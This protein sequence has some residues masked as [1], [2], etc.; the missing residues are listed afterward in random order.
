MSIYIFI[1]LLF[2]IVD[3]FLYGYGAALRFSSDAELEEYEQSKSAKARKIKAVMEHTSKFVNTVHLI[4][5][6]N[7]IIVGMLH[8]SLYINYLRPRTKDS[9]FILRGIRFDGEDIAT[10]LFVLSAFLVLYL[11]L[12]FG[13]LLPKKLAAKAAEKWVYTFITPIWLLM[14]V[15]KPVTGLVAGTVKLV[16]TVLGQNMK[17]DEDDVT[18]EDIINMV[19]EGQEQGVLLDSEAQMISN[20]FEWGDKQV[21]DI[22]TNRNS[23]LC[24]SGDMK[25]KDAINLMLSEHFTR[26]PVY[27]ENID[28]I[29]GVLYFKDAMKFYRS[30]HLMNIEISRVKNLLRKAYFVPQ[31]KKIDEVF[32]EMQ[33]SKNQ[34]SVVI[35]EYGQ[36]DGL[37]TMEDILEEIVGN[38]MD[39][40]DVE[41]NHIEETGEDEYIMDGL[42]PL[43]ELEDRF[44]LDFSEEPFETLNGLIISKLDRIPEEK[45]DFETVYQGYSFKILSVTGHR[46]ENVLV[47]K[48][49]E[50]LSENAEKQD[51]TAE[52][53]T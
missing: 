6:L 38:I 51:K 45:D 46:I 50:E 5:G 40:Y 10:V 44:G 34:L 21:Q 9:S 8:Y 13:V 33:A 19:Q 28:H 30:Q 3:F 36:T 1:L 4:T 14:T 26:Y 39:E 43:E 41:G 7:H 12:S 25:L 29:I 31:T 49:P 53:E 15:L 42:T 22:M 47:K 37:V 35:D 2:L 18:E 16:L 48:L 24:L 52:N 23:M 17:A 27:N 11:F 32:R 20:I